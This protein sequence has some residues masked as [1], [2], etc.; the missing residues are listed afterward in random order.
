MFLYA[1]PFAGFQIAGGRR[2]CRGGYGDGQIHDDWVSDNGRGM[3]SE[4]RRLFG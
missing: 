4:R 2:N 3:R 1:V